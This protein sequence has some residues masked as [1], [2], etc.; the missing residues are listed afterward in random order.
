[1]ALAFATTHENLVVFP[2][3]HNRWICDLS[4]CCFSNANIMSTSV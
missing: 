1:M 2:L 3:S 4:N